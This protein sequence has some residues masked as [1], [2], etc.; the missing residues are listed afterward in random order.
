MNCQDQLEDKTRQ[1]CGMHKG[2]TLIELLI[3]ITLT[4][5]VAAAATPFLSR[6]VLHSQF[7]AS[8]NKIT[9]AIQK[10]Q[11]LAMNNTAGEVWG[12]CQINN[13]VRVY[14]EDCEAPTQSTDFSIPASITVSGLSDIVFSRRGEPLTELNITVSSA[15]LSQQLSMTP[16]G[17]LTTAEPIATILPSPTPTPTLSPTPTATPSPTPTPTPTPTPSPNPLTVLVSITSDWETGF[18][19]DIVITNSTDQDANGWQATLERTN[20]TIY[21]SWD[22]TVIDTENEYF[23]TPTTWNGVVPANSIVDSAGF[24]ANKDENYTQPTTATAV[25]PEQPPNALTKNI[26]ITSDWETGFCAT[27]EITNTSDVTTTGW[28]A[29]INRIN[30]TI[31]NDWNANITTSETEYVFEDENWNATILPNSTDSSAGFCANKEPN[32]EP[33]TVQ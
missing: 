21:Q 24:C 19:A 7:D 14:L 25:V 5:I 16:A 9:S 30:Y 15:V 12:V 28:T 10:A 8:I 27:V 4:S 29:V 23:F 1:L 33:P 32:Y 17:G 13:I 18:C 11:T 3:V 6:F 20:Y 31:Y 26:L 22:S 2:F